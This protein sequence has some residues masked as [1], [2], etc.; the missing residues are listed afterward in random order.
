MVATSKNEACG[1]AVSPAFKGADGQAGDEDEEDFVYDVYY[2]EER[3][4]VEMEQL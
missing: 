3:P 1:V 2:S 4:D